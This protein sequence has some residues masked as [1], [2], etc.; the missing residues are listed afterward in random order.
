MC[1]YIYIYVSEIELTVIMIMIIIISIVRATLG[2]LM[3]IISNTFTTSR[4]LYG[5]GSGV[6]VYFVYAYIAWWFL[7]LLWVSLDYPF[8]FLWAALGPLCGTLGCHEGRLGL[9]RAI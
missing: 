8:G 5:G 9:P 1:I 4:P 7:A 2:M 6:C 3:H